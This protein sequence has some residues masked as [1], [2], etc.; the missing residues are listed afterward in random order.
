[1][2]LARR[3]VE[4]ASDDD[5]S[6]AAFPYYS[7]RRREIGEIPVTALR[8]SY[9]GELG[10]EFYVSPEYGGRLWDVL[11]T[12]GAADGLI[13]A[14]RAAFDTL[15][16]EKGYRLWGADMQTEY[17]PDEAGVGFALKAKAA[18]AIGQEA[19]LAARSAGVAKR[20]CCLTLDD[21]G[22]V[23]MGKEPILLDGEPAGYVTRAGFGFAVGESLAYGY[24]P[25]SVTRGRRVEIEYFGC[26]QPATIRNDPL[27]D[28]AGA[29]VRGS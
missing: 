22:V 4:R 17:L 18:P 1:G 9:V 12:A 28:P 7:A 25:A 5:W 20:L 27:F 23:V 14:G 3:V 26:R 2:P 13:A 11:W 19:A 10:W 16:L 21:P 15:R 24:L 6:G 8:V 29:R